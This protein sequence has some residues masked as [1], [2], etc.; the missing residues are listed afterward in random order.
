MRASFILITPRAE[1]VQF[2]REQI[3]LYL[4][5]C[6][7][8]SSNSNLSQSIG[9]TFFF[10]LDSNQENVINKLSLYIQNLFFFFL[11]IL[12]HSLFSYGFYLDTTENKTGYN[13]IQ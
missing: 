7:N 11:E 9:S 4:Q 12:K 1:I 5:L 13:I 10:Y 2:R 6:N 3:R 8:D